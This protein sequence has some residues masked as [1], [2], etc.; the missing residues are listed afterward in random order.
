[1]KDH[2]QIL[3][4]AVSLVLAACTKSPNSSLKTISSSP[5]AIV[6]GNVGQPENT[7]LNGVLRIEDSCSSVQ[8]DERVLLTASHCSLFRGKRKETREIIVS[9]DTL[10]V[11][12]IPHDEY[13]EA[14]PENDIAILQVSD[15]RR[16]DPL[17]NF[18]LPKTHELP[19]KLYIA[20]YGSTTFPPQPE[21]QP[22]LKFFTFIRADRQIYTVDS[23]T[24][25]D[26]EDCETNPTIQ[27]INHQLKKQ[28]L[29]CFKNPNPL[30]DTPI[31]GDSGGP[32]YSIDKKG[33][34]ALHGVFSI[35]GA[36]EE[37]VQFFC[38]EPVFPKVPWINQTLQKSIDKEEKSTLSIHSSLGLKS[39]KNVIVHGVEIATK[40]EITAEI[41]D[42]GFGTVEELQGL[43]I[44]EKILLIRRG[45]ISFSDKILSL[46]KPGPA[47]IIFYDNADGE[48]M[49]P[50]LND[51]SNWSWVIDKMDIRFISQSDGLSI[52]EEIRRGV[53]VRATLK[54]KD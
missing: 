38:Y 18:T 13:S 35:F 8:I 37:G 28:A 29:Y 23:S 40:R 4:L 22:D 39:V 3:T 12:F 10:T 17:N 33:K 21:E 54:L 6:G 11:N 52:Q 2:R 44:K 15:S 50:I 7:E 51:Y 49:I 27:A 16:L 46:E 32:L 26:C 25:E 43:D 14:S 48:L 20:G 41:I 53:S 36:N 19:D 45:K 24:V 30:T 47:G 1:M 5:Q 9:E 34:P 42:A 31:S